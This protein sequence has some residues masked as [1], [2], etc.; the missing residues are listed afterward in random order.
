M[1]EG[2][3]GEAAEAAGGAGAGAGAGRE[4][5]AERVGVG[6]AGGV[7]ARVPLHVV[8]AGFEGHGKLGVRL[9]AEELVRWLAQ[10]DH[11]FPPAFVPPAADAGSGGAPPPPRRRGGGHVTLDFSC[12]VVE[13]GSQVPKA[14]EELLLLHARPVDPGA[15]DGR[16]QVDVRA[17]ERAVEGLLREANLEKAYTVVLLNPRTPEGW[18]SYGYR[19]GFSREEA[20]RLR[21]ERD[22]LHASHELKMGSA[23]FKGHAPSPPPGDPSAERGLSRHHKFEKLDLKAETDFWAEDFLEGL[24]KRRAQYHEYAEFDRGRTGQ[25]GGFEARAKALEWLWHG[26]REERAYVSRVLGWAPRDGTE[27]P[28][29]AP[30]PPSAAGEEAAEGALNATAVPAEACLVDTWVG[31]GRYVIVD[32]AA[33]PFSWGPLEGGVGCRTHR[34]LPRV[35]RFFDE[36]ARER[37]GD[38]QELRDDVLDVALHDMTVEAGVYDHDHHAGAETPEEEAAAQTKVILAELDV[39][40]AF[41]QKFCARRTRELETCSEVQVRPSHLPCSPRRPSRVACLS[42]GRCGVLTRFP[43]LRRR[44]LPQARVG[45]LQ[46]ELEEVHRGKPS[47]EGVAGLVAKDHGWAIFGHDE[48][49]EACQACAAA[50]APRDLFLAELGATVASA[51]RHVV[52]PPILAAPRPLAPQVRFIVY[53]ILAE[54]PGAPAPPAGRRAYAAGPFNLAAFKAELQRLVLPSQAL[55]VS[56][57]RVEAEQ[58]PG[59][60]M[61]FEV[62]VENVRLPALSAAGRYGFYGTAARRSLDSATL[63]AQLQHVSAAQLG[64]KARGGGRRGGPAGTLEIPVFLFATSGEHGPTYIDQRFLARPLAG[65]SVVLAAYTAGEVQ[66]AGDFTCNGRPVLSS[67][68]LFMKAVLGAAA[69]A[70]AGLA[71]MHL[72]HSPARDVQVRTCRSGAPARSPK[73]TSFSRPH[74]DDAQV[75]DWTWSVG[76]NPL[77][78]TAPGH[79]FSQLQADAAQRNAV[80][81]AL[82]ASLDAVDASVRALQAQPA[83]PAAAEGA[84]ERALRTAARDWHAEAVAAAKGAADEFEHLDW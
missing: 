63:L 41:A 54:P 51:I 65:G 35:E 77:S 45:D 2:A 29:D 73:L 5:L 17:M 57:Y 44:R 43:Q 15:A 56:Y 67:E 64:A 79:R 37:G 33:G 6:P 60:Q 20:L 3:G 68:D 59:L 9:E 72:A 81:A 46:K 49:G 82:E 75:A 47:A 21:G 83:P 71:P 38:L 34:T 25:D 50:A 24:E 70:L 27:G 66:L 52:A 28:S 80:V 13:A 61:A 69:Q 4:T 7:E 10:L 36:L 12:Q 14:L 48:R 23:F 55:H 30:L 19:P 8:L 39:Y 11:R 62:A 76:A 78:A 84:A 58:D 1:E 18:K 26:T 42:A 22:L 74:R 40:E 32:L 31:R 53:D 16:F